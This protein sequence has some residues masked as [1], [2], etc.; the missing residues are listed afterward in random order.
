MLQE[1][2]LKKFHVLFPQL[3]YKILV[4]SNGF[5]L[6]GVLAV[7]FY[8][9]FQIS[10]LQLSNQNLIAQI[11]ELNVRNT[12]LLQQLT[13]NQQFIDSQK[14]SWNV[15]F[16]KILIGTLGVIGLGILFKPMLLN[17]IPFIDLETLVKLEKIKNFILSP[18]KIKCS[19]YKAEVFSGLD[20][21]ELRLNLTEDGLIEQLS[22]KD[23]FSLK[24]VEFGQFL[25]NLNLKFLIN[26]PD[27]LNSELIQAATDQARLLLL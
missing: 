24:F 2:N 5:V 13:E 11:Q 8:T 18:L 22:I 6:I 23:P 19:E 27:C 16:K 17:L 3:I 15:P 10:E 1:N 21:Y 4:L 20:K 9:H 12:E 14:Q 26:T 7:F 25:E